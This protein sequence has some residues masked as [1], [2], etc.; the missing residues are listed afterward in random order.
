[1]PSAAIVIAGDSIEGRRKKSIPESE[2]RASETS[3][4]GISPTVATS[5]PHK[6]LRSVAIA[7]AASE[8]GTFSAR[9]FGHAAMMMMTAKATKSA[10]QFMSKPSE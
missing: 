4:R 8:D 3:E 2:R 7:I 5:K 10:A 1:M 6:R 9:R